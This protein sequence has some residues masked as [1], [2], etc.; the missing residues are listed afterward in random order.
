MYPTM[1]PTMDPKIY[2]VKNKQYIYFYRIYFWIH[3]WI[4]FCRIYFLCPY[5]DSRA[6]SLCTRFAFCRSGSS[7]SSW[8]SLKSS[9]SSRGSGLFYSI[10]RLCKMQQ[11]ITICAHF[12]GVNRRQLSQL[13]RQLCNVIK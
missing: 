7:C 2:F 11:A 13:R 4:H 12:S 1:Y 9:R 6:L 10:A 8:S 3:C 5:I